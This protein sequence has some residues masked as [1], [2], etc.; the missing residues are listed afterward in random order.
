MS[1]VC[2]VK[3]SDGRERGQTNTEAPRKAPAASTAQHS[4]AQLKEKRA[5]SQR[6]L[7]HF[8]AAGQ[9]PANER[10]GPFQKSIL[11]LDFDT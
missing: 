7:P 11:A 1:E 6:Q 8:H 10:N 4:T 2:Q 3:S 5:S 9:G